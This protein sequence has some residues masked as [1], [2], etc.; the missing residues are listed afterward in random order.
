M[1]LEP[2]LETL[3]GVF[4]NKLTEDDREPIATF[5]LPF[6]EPGSMW[7]LYPPKLQRRMKEG[8][9]GSALLI[10]VN[11]LTLS[12]PCSYCP[13]PPLMLRSIVPLLSIITD[14]SATDCNSMFV[15]SYHLSI[16][17]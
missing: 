15:C 10:N 14:A 1:I 8:M 12:T 17:Y 6:V 7:A 3:K 9:K 5:E 16:H 2:L 11:K 4:A 13:C